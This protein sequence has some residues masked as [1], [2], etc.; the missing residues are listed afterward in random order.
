MATAVDE[1]AL[2][3]LK[4]AL[5]VIETVKEESNLYKDNFDQLRDSFEAQQQRLESLSQQLSIITKEKETLEAEKA[6]DQKYWKTQLETKAKEI[7]ELKSK[8]LDQK[9]IDVLRMRIAEELES[10]Q[11]KR[12]TALKH[13]TEKYRDMFYRLRRELE[14]LKTEYDKMVAEQETVVKEQN[15]VHQDEI[16]AMESSL[17][18]MQSTIENTTDPGTLRTLRRESSELQCQIQAILGELTE[19]RAEKETLSVNAES[20]DRLNKKRLLEESTNAK[21]IQAERDSLQSK[22][23]SLEQEVKTQLK[24]NDSLQEENGLLRREI[25]KVKALSETSLHRHQ[26][27]LSDVKTSHMKEKANLEHSVMDYKRK[28]Q[29]LKGALKSS[30]D[31]TQSARDKL[32]SKEKELLEKIQIAREEEWAKVAKLETENIDLSNQVQLLKQQLTD[33]TAKE[34]TYRKHVEIEL[35]ELKKEVRSLSTRNASLEATNQKLVDDLDKQNSTCNTHH[36]SKM[37]EL[38]IRLAGAER[39]LE[40][41]RKE[42]SASRDRLNKLQGSCQLSQNESS[43]LQSVLEKERQAYQH[44][45]ERQKAMWTKERQVLTQRLE[46]LSAELEG[47]REKPAELSD[48]L[49][50]Y[51][52]KYESKVAQFNAKIK[53]YKVE[54]KKLISK[55]EEEQQRNKSQKLE[56]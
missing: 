43:Q 50:Q 52:K 15:L 32:A 39:D 14:L 3:K 6:E 45:L 35:N 4:V 53:E 33:Q 21:I 27:E 36:S 12:W 28:I 18:A 40:I 44:N 7:A 8:D 42:E 23:R 24:G 16:R 22:C 25:D 41:S 34:E 29:D 54:N 11:E 38:E 9:D 46:A 49:D 17:R 31:Q 26:V 19:V 2:E 10:S 13:E 48:V 55:L 51:R 30:Q 37:Q 20:Q 1:S 56:V 47:L 5:G